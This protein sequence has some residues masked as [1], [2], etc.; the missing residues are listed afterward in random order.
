MALIQFDLVLYILSFRIIGSSFLDIHTYFYLHQR[1]LFCLHIYMSN[2][3]I[4][5]NLYHIL[6]SYYYRHIFYIQICIFDIDILLLYCFNFK[7]EMDNMSQG[8]TPNNKNIEYLTP[9]FLK[10]IYIVLLICMR[11]IT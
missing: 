4:I 5:F 7:L 8:I 6:C 11:N 10:N 9:I 3:L 1:F 2:Y